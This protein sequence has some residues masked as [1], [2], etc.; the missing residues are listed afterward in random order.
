MALCFFSPKKPIGG[1][2]RDVSSHLSVFNCW[3]VGVFS[4]D[5]LVHDC[6]GRPPWLS[7]YTANTGVLCFFKDL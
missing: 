7:S 1:F 6:R 4:G 2:E 5:E 3:S